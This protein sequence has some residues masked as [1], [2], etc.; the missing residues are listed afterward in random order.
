MPIFKLEQ[1]STGLN[2]RSAAFSGRRALMMNSGK[3]W[4]SSVTSSQTRMPQLLQKQLDMGPTK[5]DT[6]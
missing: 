5:R 4:A 6:F 1:F 2:S 3:P